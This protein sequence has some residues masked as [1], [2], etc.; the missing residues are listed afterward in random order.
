MA[1]LKCKMC[2]GTMEYDLEQNLVFCPYCGSK[3]ILYDRK[4]TLYEQFQ[5]Q[6]A[7]LLNQPPGQVPEEGFWV[8][9]S[10]EELL[11]EDGSKIEIFYY[12]KEQADMCTMYVAKKS[13]LYLF[14]EKHAG[15]ADHFMKIIQKLTYPNPDMERELSNYIPELL[16][17]CRLSDGRILLAVKRRNGVHPL[18]LLGTLLDRHVAWIIS[19]L[20]NLCC[21]LEYNHLVLNALTIENLFVD[22]ANH[23]IYLYGGWWFA[24]YEG[25]ETVGAS[26]DV[27]PCLDTTRKKIWQMNKTAKV[28]NHSL[29]DL[30]SIRMTAIRLLGYADRKALEEDH[31]LPGP[32]RRF[33]LESP[34]RTAREDFAQWDRVLLN[35]YGERKFIPLTVTEEELYCRNAASCEV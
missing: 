21:L 3:S 15:Y 35:S 12:A 5:N 8:E 20:E 14:E 23:Q 16:T 25:V 2:G 26:H 30:K 19:R 9:A 10:R 32:F 17:Q 24:G 34:M 13:I 33:L 18:K 29:T 7:A 6:Y 4:E 28:R 1:I 22:P 11:R 31:L 27:I